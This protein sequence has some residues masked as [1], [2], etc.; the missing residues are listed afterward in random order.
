MFLATGVL[1]LLD[2]APH[3]SLPPSEE[4]RLVLMM[5]Q[6]P[7]YARPPEASLRMDRPSLLPWVLVKASHMGWRNAF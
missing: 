7:K 4:P 1:G 5:R 6:R 3:V 2:S